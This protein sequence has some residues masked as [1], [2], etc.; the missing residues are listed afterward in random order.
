MVI[1]LRNIAARGEK[2]MGEIAD[3]MLDGTFCQ[4]CGTIMFYGPSIEDGLESPGH[5]VNCSDCGEIE[6]EK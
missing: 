3:M 4:Q 2:T 5:P 1:V 6:S